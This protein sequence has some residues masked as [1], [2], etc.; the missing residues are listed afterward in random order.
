M[1]RIEGNVS[2]F[3]L[4][5]LRFYIGCRI[6]RLFHSKKIIITNIDSI[7]LSFAFFRWLIPE[8]SQQVHISQ[9]LS[10]ELDSPECLS[11]LTFIRRTM[12]ACL[13][14][15]IDSLLVLGE[16]AK[17]SFFKHDLVLRSQLKC[18]Q[19]G[20]DTFFWTPRRDNNSIQLNEGNPFLLSVGS[21][22][23]RDYETLLA[24]KFNIDIIV[25]SR[26]P[27]PPTQG[28]SQISDINDVEL[29]EY[30]RQSALVVIPLKDISQP[31]GQSA[32]LQAMACGK[33]VVISDT[34]GFWDRTRLINGEYIC[35]V[36]HSDPQGLSTTVNQ[37]LSEPEQ[38]NRIGEKGAELVRSHFHM[39]KMGQELLGFCQRLQQQSEGPL[40]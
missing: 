27:L 26:T 12:T 17:E 25:I 34:R 32:T 31:S 23:G 11:F 8:R 19:F 21:D 15:E 14:R 5:D 4:F 40:V 7:G 30:Y 39:E 28:M 37:L 33:A 36:P 29:R 24:A 1:T 16:G 9:G 2:R 22:A 3:L 10:N 20:V 18:L 35:M 6:Y 38:L 13:C